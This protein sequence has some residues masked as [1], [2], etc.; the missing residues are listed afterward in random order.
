LKFVITVDREIHLPTATTGL[1]PIGYRGALLSSFLQVNVYVT[2][3][4]LIVLLQIA[5]KMGLKNKEKTYN[6][7][8]FICVFVS[9]EELYIE[10]EREGEKRSSTCL[11][12]CT[13]VAAVCYTQCRLLCVSSQK[14]GWKLNGCFTIFSNLRLELICLSL[15]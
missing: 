5:N 3:N 11:S 13:G 7:Y 12:R 1:E 15:M 4:L 6:Q 14:N 8:D 9:I 10:R 2:H